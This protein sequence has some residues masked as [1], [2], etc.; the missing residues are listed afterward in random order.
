MDMRAAIINKNEKRKAT[1]R[2][3]V[4]EFARVPNLPQDKNVTDDQVVKL[5][6]KAVASES[7][8][9]TPDQE[10]IAILQEYLP[11]LVTDEEVLAWIKENVDFSSLKNKMQAIKLVMSNFSGRVDGNNVKKLIENNF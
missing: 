10:F 8:L 6:N 1:L 3:I 7:T 9:P 5:I 11:K 2:F 4:G